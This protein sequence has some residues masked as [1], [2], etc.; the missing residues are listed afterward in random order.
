MAITA[1]KAVWAQSRATG[2]TR[3]VLLALADHVNEQRLQAGYGCEAW[4][5]QSTLAKMCRSSRS[6]VK[7]ALRRLVELGEIVDTGERKRRGTV[8][9]EINLDAA[10]A[11][12]ADSEPGH[13]DMAEYRP[14]GEEEGDDLAD[15]RHDLADLQPDLA[16]SGQR[17]GRPL[18]HKPVVEPEEEPEGEQ[19]V[20]LAFGCGRLLSFTANSQ[21]RQRQQPWL[22]PPAPPGRPGNSGGTAQASRGERERRSA[23]RPQGAT[24]EDQ[25]GTTA[26]CNRALHRLP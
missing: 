3:L 2:N 1:T 17:P 19:Q 14:G 24:A 9:W 25:E 20:A 6:T 21:Q 7:L 22:R 10:S 13:S 11:D 18:S 16:D 26:R 8:V 12:L 15:S 5:S 4:P 23:R